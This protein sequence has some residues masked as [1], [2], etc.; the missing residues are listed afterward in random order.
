MII[1]TE[2]NPLLSLYYLGGIILKEL[3]ARSCITIDDLFHKV[4][5]KL[6]KDLPID[7]FYYALDWLYIISLVKIDVKG[8]SLCESK[9]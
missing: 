1:N 8:I 9:N 4:K 6:H 3:R 7:F 2:R 5:N